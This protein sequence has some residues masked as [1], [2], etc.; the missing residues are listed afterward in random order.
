MRMGGKKHPS[1]PSVARK[2]RIKVIPKSLYWLQHV[3]SAGSSHLCSGD[4]QGQ[5]GP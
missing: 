1:Q 4:T 2:T 3:S 5:A